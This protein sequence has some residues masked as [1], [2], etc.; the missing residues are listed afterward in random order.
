MSTSMVQVLT[1]IYV[2]IHVHAHVYAHAYA[3][4]DGYGTDGELVQ[5]RLVT[6]VEPYDG[7]DVVCTL[8]VSDGSEAR[9][10]QPGGKA[11]PSASVTI[12]GNNVLA[13]KC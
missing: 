4:V 8:S 6:T 7:A 5:V 11:V 12:S 3:H 9:F 13:N 2:G 1:T 10:I